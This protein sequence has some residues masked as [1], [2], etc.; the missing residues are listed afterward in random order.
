MTETP[1][2]PEPLSSE[3]EVIFA[4]ELN[5][6]NEETILRDFSVQK[7]IRDLKQAIAKAL[8]SPEEWDSI[9]AF[10]LAE[11]LADCMPIQ[12]HPLHEAINS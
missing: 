1:K 12:Q 11:H 10:Y 5:A 4:E 7:S 6:D 8:N 2:P 9:Q 3:A